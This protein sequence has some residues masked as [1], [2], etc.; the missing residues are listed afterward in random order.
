MLK[1]KNFWSN[2]RKNK[3]EQHSVLKMYMSSA[4]RS[5]SDK[6]DQKD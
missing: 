1:T 6:V 2:S 3:A 5:F 4:G